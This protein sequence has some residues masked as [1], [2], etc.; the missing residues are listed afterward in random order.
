MPR[1]R[2]HRLLSFSFLIHTPEAQK[3]EK[4]TISDPITS[5][6]WGKKLAQHTHTVTVAH[7]SNLF[8][9]SRL[10]FEARSTASDATLFR[11]T[12]VNHPLP[13][14][15]CQSATNRDFIFS[16]TRTSAAL[17]LSGADTVRP[18]CLRERRTLS[19][20]PALW[21]HRMVQAR[22]SRRFSPTSQ[23]I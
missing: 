7:T 2:I 1:L 5:W 20:L 15:R 3:K 16:P 19:G 21:H 6:L 8:D 9:R 13:T 14:S 10:V 12:R 4:P 11:V 17:S 22:I 23:S 18:I